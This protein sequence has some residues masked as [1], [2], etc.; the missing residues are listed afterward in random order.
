MLGNRVSTF[1]VEG[2]HYALILA[3]NLGLPVIEYDLRPI[4]KLA[5]FVPA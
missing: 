5:L 2:H 3:E 4:Q 1:A